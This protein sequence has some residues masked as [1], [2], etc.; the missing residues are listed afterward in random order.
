MISSDSD[1][2]RFPAKF[3]QEMT[4]QLALVCQKPSGR[5]PQVFGSSRQT[6][7]PGF[8]RKRSDSQIYCKNGLLL[9]YSTNQRGS[10]LIQILKIFIFAS[11]RLGTA[12][13]SVLEAMGPQDRA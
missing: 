4:M 3:V 13:G 11:E 10:N 6:H 2:S 8:L 5:V 1:F 7:E 12:R 9:R